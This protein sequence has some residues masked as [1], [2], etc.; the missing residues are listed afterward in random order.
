[1]KAVV[2]KVAVHES[3]E[4]VTKRLFKHQVTR[5]ADSTTFSVTLDS[6]FEQLMEDEESNPTLV[7]L[8]EGSKDLRM[9]LR[10][11]LLQLLFERRVVVKIPGAHSAQKEASVKARYPDWLTKKCGQTRGDNTSFI[12]LPLRYT[13]A[14]KGVMV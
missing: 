9:I 3:G 8:T 12:E 5:K 7:C 11:T 2:D 13:R 4:E 6:V 1:M 14:Y 10:G